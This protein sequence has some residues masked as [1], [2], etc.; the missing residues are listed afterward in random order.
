[1]SDPAALLEESLRAWRIEGEVR[2]EADAITI[3]AAGKRL[4]VTVAPPDLP[5][6]WMLDAGTRQRGVTGIP[7]LLRAVRTALQPDYPASRLQLAAR[8]V[9]E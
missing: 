7:G 2:R 8:P 3:E 1:V 9:L 6:R 4:R 5:F